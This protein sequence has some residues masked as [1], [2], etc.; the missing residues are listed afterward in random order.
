M[1]IITIIVDGADGY[2]RNE[3]KIFSLF[4]KSRIW[5]D[6]DFLE[7]GGKAFILFAFSSDH[8]IE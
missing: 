5:Y 4:C 2:E 7:K 6:E 3:E 1:I 8:I